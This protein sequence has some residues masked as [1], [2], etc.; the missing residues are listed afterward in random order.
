MTLED[1]KKLF[2]TRQSCRK[3]NPDR[4]PDSQTLKEI[5]EM[6]M[7]SP[8]ACNSQP[9]KV[10]VTNVPEKVRGLSKSVQPFG[11]NKFA[12]KC[13]AF[14]VITETAACASEKIGVKYT[15]RDF[16]AN[17][18]GILCAHYVLAAKSAGI[19]SCILGLF[20]EK[21]VKAVLDIPED[22]KVRLVIALGY[23][24][25]DDKI[26]NKVRKNLGDTCEF[27]LQ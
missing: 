21:A 9:W 17:D 2:E 4:I 6:S 24:A 12:D 11:A 7:M 26:R 8:S 25:E 10:Y 18:L 19:D 1:M 13:T 14:A 27:I 23:A 15:K 20:E 3:Y 5:T 16:I 22:L